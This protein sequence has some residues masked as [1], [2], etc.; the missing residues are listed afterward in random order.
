MPCMHDFVGS[1]SARVLNTI[2]VAI[3]LSATLTAAA[4]VLDFNDLGPSRGG[5]L[6]PAIY[7]GIRWE[8]SSWHYMTAPTG[9]TFLALSTPS[10]LVRLAPGGSE[11]TLQ[12]ARVWSRRGADALGDFYFFLYHNG[13]TVYNGFEDPDGRQRFDGTPRVFA[14]S[15]V[16]PID[17]F[18]IGFDNDDHDHIAID[19]LELVFQTPCTADLDGDG[20]VGGSDLGMLLASWGQPGAADIDGD[21]VVLG[22]DLAALLGA[23]GACN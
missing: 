4:D 13:V 1:L 9:N 2:A 16:G 5:A 6:M 18:A 14:P 15:Y 22:S 10:T 21:G 12:G 19:D 11:F 8:G 20:A 17:A 23:W 3:T 7:H